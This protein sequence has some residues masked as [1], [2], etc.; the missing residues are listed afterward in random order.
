MARI[1][2]AASP[3]VVVLT[4]WMHILSEAFIDLMGPVPIKNLRPAFPGA[5]D[6]ANAI[7]RTYE[8]WKRGEVTRLGCMIHRVVKEVDKGEPIIVREVDFK[9]A[10]TLRSLKKDCLVSIIVEGAKKVLKPLICK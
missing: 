6:G 1:V 4:G 5:F 3:D 10:R 7:E 9:R 2:L 8:T